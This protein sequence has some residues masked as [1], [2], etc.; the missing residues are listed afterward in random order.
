MERSA[1]ILNLVTDEPN[2]R[3]IQRYLVDDAAKFTGAGSVIFAASRPT[4]DTIE[5]NPNNYNNPLGGSRSSANL[6]RSSVRESRAMRLKL[7]IV[8]LATYFCA[9]YPA[10]AAFVIKLKT[11]MSLLLAATGRTASRCCLKLMTGLSALI[12]P[13]W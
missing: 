6:R 4:D 8:I 13:S 9:I 5:L 3:T 12:N 10:E 2:F 7:P 11:A 1:I